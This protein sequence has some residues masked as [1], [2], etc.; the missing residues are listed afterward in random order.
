[1]WRFSTSPLT[2]KGVHKDNYLQFNSSTARVYSYLL[3]KF[4]NT[5]QKGKR[6]KNAFP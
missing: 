1:M 5:S 2:S 6:I 4:D 3:I